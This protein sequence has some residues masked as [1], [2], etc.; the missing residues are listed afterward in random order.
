MS[1]AAQFLDEAKRLID[2]LDVEAIERMAMLL[3]QARR[4]GGR[5]FIPGVGGGA[6]GASHAVE[7]R[8]GS[9]DGRVRASYNPGNVGA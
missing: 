8:H 2:G 1:H 3:E 4:R 6:D 5:L 9:V 7:E